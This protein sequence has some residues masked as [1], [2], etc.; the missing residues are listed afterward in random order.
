MV[1]VA[2]QKR[3]TVS[4]IFKINKQAISSSITTTWHFAV[5]NIPTRR[6]SLKILY[7]PE[8][9]KPKTIIM[10]AEVVKTKYVIFEK[11][12][13]SVFS[14]YVTRLNDAYD[15]IIKMRP[16]PIIWTTTIP[17]RLNLSKLNVLE[18]SRP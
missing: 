10:V 7:T 2:N 5:L 1:H 3:E 11:Y 12:L 9:A 13:V 8:R 4:E 16:S 17:V 6:I 15:E 14:K 18:T